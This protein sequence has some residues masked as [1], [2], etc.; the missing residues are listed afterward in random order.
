MHIR[1][2]GRRK[3]PRKVFTA[4]LA[5]CPTPLGG[6]GGR[7]GDAAVRERRPRIGGCD[8]TRLKAGLQ[9]GGT[10]DLMGMQR[11]GGY[12]VNLVGFRVWYF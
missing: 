6:A 8:E 5:I 7:A 1:R 4:I 2:M 11:L 9:T 12:G 10:A 3:V